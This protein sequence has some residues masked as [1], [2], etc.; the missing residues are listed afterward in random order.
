MDHQQQSPV[1]ESMDC[2]SRGKVVGQMWIGAREKDDQNLRAKIQTEDQLC[3]PSCQMFLCLRQF[4][5]PQL[6]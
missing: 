5:L 4:A 3:V 2:N 1:D 6:C